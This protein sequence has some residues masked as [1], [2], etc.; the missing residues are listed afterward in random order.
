MIPKNRIP[1]HPGE[2]L[3]EEFLDPLEVS[4]VELAEHLDVP[5]QRVNELFRGKRGITPDTAWRLSQALNTSPEFWTNL[6][7]NY[8]L[9]RKRPKQALPPLRC[10]S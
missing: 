1:T 7:C 9:A 2:V 10:A 3:K 8:D 6:Q 5:V 4:Q